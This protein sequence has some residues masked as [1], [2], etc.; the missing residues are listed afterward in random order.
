M[1][2]LIWRT[3]HGSHYTYMAAQMKDIW[4]EFKVEASRKIVTYEINPGKC[5][6]LSFGFGIQYQHVQFH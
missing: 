5:F 2:E 3:A 6:K 4:P 1:L